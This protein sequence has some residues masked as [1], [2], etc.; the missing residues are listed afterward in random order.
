MHIY[1]YIYIYV[2][3]CVCVCEDSVY[4]EQMVL[5]NSQ[6]HP[7]RSSKSDDHIVTMSQ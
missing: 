6:F 2:C 4:T 5:G 3:V 1:I 7:I